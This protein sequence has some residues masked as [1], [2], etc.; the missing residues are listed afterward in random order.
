MLHLVA[1]GKKGDRINYDIFVDHY[2]EWLKLMTHLG[3]Y[4]SM[5]FKDMHRRAMHML[6]NRK[7]MHKKLK[8]IHENS[9]EYIYLMDFINLEFELGVQAMNKTNSKQQFN[10][11]LAKK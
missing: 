4:V 11:A 3:P 10:A 8:L 6:R 7:L 5:G 9:N 2:F 1:A